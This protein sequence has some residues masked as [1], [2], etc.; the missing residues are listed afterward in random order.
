[1][2]CIPLAFLNN[3]GDRKLRNRNLMADRAQ[4]GVFEKSRLA[5]R[6]KSRSENL[7]ADKA[8]AG[9]VFSKDSEALSGRRPLSD[10]ISHWRSRQ[11]DARGM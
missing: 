5:R 9:V 1:M 3:C 10:V 7:G 6:H 4:A 2:A 11:F 8:Q